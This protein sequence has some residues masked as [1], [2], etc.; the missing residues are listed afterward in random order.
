MIALEMGSVLLKDCAFVILDLQGPIVQYV[1]IAVLFTFQLLRHLQVVKRFR[2]LLQHL[3][4]ISI[5][6]LF[7]MREEDSI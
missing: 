1:S 2:V 7:E 6:S 4:G 3:N 5:P